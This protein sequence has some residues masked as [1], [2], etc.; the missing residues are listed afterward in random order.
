MSNK[1][2]N[3]LNNEFKRIFGGKVMKLSVDGGFTCPNRDGTKGSRG[4]IFCGEEGSG[5]FAGSRQIPI[6]EQLE[7]QKD[8]LSKKWNSDQY[9]IYFQNFTNTY[10]TIDR[11]RSLYYEALELEGVVGIAIAT[12]PDCL[13]E[14]VIEL[15]TDINKKTFLWVELG[16][17]SI[18][19]KTEKF[20]RRGYPLSLYDKAIDEL[21]RNNIRAVTHLIIGFPNESKDEIIQSV[22]HVAK[23]NTWGIKLH[24]L[25]IQRDTDL[26]NYYIKNPFSIMTMD[27]YIDITIESLERIPKS[28]VV[29]RITGDGKKDLLIEPTWSLNKLKVLTSID[30]E[31]KIRDTFQ[32]K[33]FDT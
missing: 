28:M 2:Y 15:L 19:E 9:I 21:K 5:E 26:Y 32:G 17:Q 12:R 1:R 7:Q 10:G 3:T 14:E 6:K 27:E 13:D 24:S 16:L 30:K 8:L 22:K 31:L 33:L 4:C 23:T 11:L 18:H 20:I 29:H 25:Y